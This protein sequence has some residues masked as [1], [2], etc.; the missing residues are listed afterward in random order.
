MSRRFF[1]F[2]ARG[3]ALDRVVHIG[4]FDRFCFPPRRQ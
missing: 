3:D 4:H 1:L 2:Q